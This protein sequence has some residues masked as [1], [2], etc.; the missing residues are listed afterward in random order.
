MIWAFIDAGVKGGPGACA[1]TKGRSVLTSR[2]RQVGER[3][4]P[5]RVTEHFVF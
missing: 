4:K 3:A 2:A 1:L 5:S